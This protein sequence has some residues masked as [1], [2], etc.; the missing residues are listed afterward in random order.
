[1]LSVLEE[2]LLALRDAFAELEVL[3]EFALLDDLLAEALSEFELLEVLLLDA[4]SES[5]LLEA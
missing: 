1:M 3:S 4:L 2:D 5:V